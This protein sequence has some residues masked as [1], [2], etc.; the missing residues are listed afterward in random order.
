MNMQCSSRPVG[1]VLPHHG[2]ILSLALRGLH[3]RGYARTLK[4]TES[5]CLKVL[6]IKNLCNKR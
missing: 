6:D 1:H 2:R 5:L 4:A 3:N